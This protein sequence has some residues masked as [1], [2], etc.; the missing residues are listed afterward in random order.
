M[1]LGSAS[2][3]DDIAAGYWDEGLDAIIEA[4]VARRKW[5][6]DHQG[7]QNMINF[8]PG[9]KVR[10]INIR[11]KYLAGITGEVSPKRANRAGDLMVDID[12]K[13][14]YRLGRYGRQLSIPASSLE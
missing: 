5:V 6:K 3:F 9:T 2:I 12:P 13:C 10:V 1:S 7:A 11:P 14:Y 8:V 4:A